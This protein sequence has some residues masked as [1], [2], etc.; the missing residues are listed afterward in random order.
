M[1]VSRASHNAMTSTPIQRDAHGIPHVVAEDEAGMYFGQGLAHATDR[2]LQM[3]LMRIVGQG[4][5]SEVLDSSDDS[6]RM[7]RFF[8]RANWSDNARL[9]LE[10]LDRR[11]QGL[12][13]DY[14]RGV[15]HALSQRIPWELK[16]CRHRPEPWT[17]ED[18]VLLLRMMGYLT[19]AAS[20]GEMERLFVEMVQ[21]NVAE[22]KLQE[23]FPGILNGLDVELLKQVRL[24]NRLVPAELWG[25][26]LPRIMASNNWVISGGRTT[27]GKPLL[28]NDVHL[29]GNRLPGVWCEMS[30]RCQHRYLLG[31]TI[32]GLPGLLVGRNNDLAWGVTYAFMD[33]EDS[34]IERCQDGKYYR[35]TEDRWLEFRRRT[36]TILRK[37]KRPATVHFHENEHGVL[38]GDPVVD[39][40]YLATRWAAADSG[41]GAL[42]ASFGLLNAR[43]VDQGM[44]LLGEVETAWNF[45]FAD[46]EGDIGYQMSG[47]SPKRRQGVSGFVPL[48]GWKPENDWLGFVAPQDLPHVKNPAAGFFATAN[49]D[50]NGHGRSTPINLP[51]GPYRADRILQLLVARDNFTVADICAMHFDVYSR[52]AELFMDILRPLLPDSPAADCL[53]HWDL[54]YTAES[55][56]AWLFEQFFKELYREVF[57]KS[58]MGERVV[59]ALRRETGAFVDFYH[60]FDRILL[61]E[62]SAWFDGRGREEVFQK[63]A[64]GALD[65]PLRKWG[66]VQRFD[67][68]NIFFNGKL[69]RFLGFDRGPFTAMGNRSTIHQ[70]QIY[71][72]GG[73]R[74]SFLPSFR[75]V[76]DLATDE[77]HTTLA[78]SPSDRRFS[79][80]YASG[81][82]DWLT[83]RYKTLSGAP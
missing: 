48:P 28:A 12:L 34:W 40:Y 39:G 17:P 50:L 69:P 10:T 19:L 68:T 67:M 21:A 33:A 56:G 35:E 31:G 61:S 45:V 41:S 26:P 15:N 78:G 24:G 44:K 23:L 72:S 81:I 36:E 77:I 18:T 79:K 70:A 8:R 76:T 63:A 55:E 54:R 49:N 6:L 1:Q 2:G 65:Q 47:R 46:R 32:P 75:V 29:E 83:G 58:G 14:C 37:R 60:N 11:E 51:M 30:L 38:D 82:S 71:T 64:A 73:R 3:L 66:D 5:I 52:Q 16:L 4:R 74:T 80:W 59:D 9:P 20:Q 57:G 25:L 27:S 53:R 42:R 13:E 7:D 22:E 43:S 62:N